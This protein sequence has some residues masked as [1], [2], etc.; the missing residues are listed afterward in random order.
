MQNHNWW[1]WGD[2]FVDAFDDDDTEDRAID[3]ARVNAAGAT[4]I[5]RMRPHIQ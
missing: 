1:G 4:G 5:C 3:V 2:S